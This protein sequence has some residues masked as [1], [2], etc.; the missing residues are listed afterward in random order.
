MSA[1]TIPNKIPDRKDLAPAIGQ[2]YTT[3]CENLATNWSGRV[4][5]FAV[6]VLMCRTF[7]VKITA[8]TL[9]PRSRAA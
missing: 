3:V 5:T 6:L 7:D 2:P 9:D 4:K 8:L 1:P